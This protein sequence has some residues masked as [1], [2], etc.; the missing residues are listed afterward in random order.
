MSYHSL[1]VM[2][3]TLQPADRRDNNGA[4]WQGRKYENST[5]SVGK[6]NDNRCKFTRFEVAT[7]VRHYPVGSIYMTV[8]KRK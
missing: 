5:S 3:S 7:T 6:V 1:R 2:G 8:F 4:R